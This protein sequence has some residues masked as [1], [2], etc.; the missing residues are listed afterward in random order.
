MAYANASRTRKLFINIISNSLKYYEKGTSPLIDISSVSDN[1]TEG[2]MIEVHVKDN[3]IGFDESYMEKILLPFGRLVT[4][5]QYPGSGLG[6]AVV[7]QILD[8]SGGA[9]GVK[10]QE[11]VGSTFIVS[12]PSNWYGK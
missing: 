2:N 4:Q 6:L 1:G 5:D 8:H 9:I 10:S 12:L 3:G 11:G 7:K